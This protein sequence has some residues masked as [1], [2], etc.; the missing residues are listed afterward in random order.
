MK[1][2]DL[3]KLQKLLIEFGQNIHFNNTLI[4]SLAFVISSVKQELDK[5]HE[6]VI[7]NRWGKY[8]G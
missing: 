2:K 3:V 5:K 6:Q 4:S 8:N 1:I 7:E